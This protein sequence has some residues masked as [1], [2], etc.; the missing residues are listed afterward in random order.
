MDTFFAI[1]K[2]VG[3]RISEKRVHRFNNSVA[4]YACCADQLKSRASYGTPLEHMSK[5]SIKERTG[6]LLA[7][8]RIKCLSFLY[9]A[10]NL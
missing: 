8:C 1:N 10:V 3:R 6:R 7:E 4:V 9:C 5:T 2:I